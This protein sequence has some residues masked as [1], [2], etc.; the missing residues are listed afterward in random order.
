MFEWHLFLQLYI[1]EKAIYFNASN[2][3][4]GFVIFAFQTIQPSQH[5]PDKVTLIP[6]YEQRTG[7]DAEIGWDYLRYGNY[8]G[9]GVPYNIFKWSIKKDVPNHLERAGKSEKIPHGFNFFIEEGVEVVGNF[10]CFACHSSSING[11][12][13]AGIGNNASNFTGERIKNSLSDRNEWYAFGT[14]NARGNTKHICLWQEVQN[15]SAL[16]WKRLLLA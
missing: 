16:M 15:T 14:A 8:I 11:K 2:Y 7:G 13:I 1:Y 10:N 12:F 4:V 9:A 5:T 3:Q 6:E